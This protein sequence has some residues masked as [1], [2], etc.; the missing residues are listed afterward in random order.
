MQSRI[1]Q[2]ERLVAEVE[3]YLSTVD[4]FRREGCEP[5]WRRE[6]PPARKPRKKE[7]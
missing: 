1:E 3:R 4:A 7:T 6:S 5:S 2:R